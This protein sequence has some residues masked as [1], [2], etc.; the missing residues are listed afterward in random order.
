MIYIVYIFI[1]LY[2]SCMANHCNKNSAET[3][4]RNRFPKSDPGHS[5]P[6]VVSQGCI[7]RLNE[8]VSILLLLSP[9]SFLMS[10][11]PLIETS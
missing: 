11:A 8:I 2:G 7:Y 3:T 5:T 9:P 1:I 4:D 10:L 6:K